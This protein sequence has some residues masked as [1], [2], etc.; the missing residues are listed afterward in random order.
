MA[1]ALLPQASP[2]LSQSLVLV[3]N[4]ENEEACPGTLTAKFLLI[5]VLARALAHRRL[6]V[7]ATTGCQLT[8]TCHPRPGLSEHPQQNPSPQALHSGRQTPCFPG[9]ACGQEQR[10]RASVSSPA[11]PFP[12]G[13]HQ[14]PL[15][16]PLPALGHWE[17]AVGS[18]NIVCSSS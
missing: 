17:H 10:L 8:A 13:P 7:R 11:G 14:A 1:L 12:R 2:L 9:P 4:M 16:L 18:V 15:V 3:L 6:S 5:K